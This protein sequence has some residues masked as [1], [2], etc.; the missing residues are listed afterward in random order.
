MN[1]KNWWK[2]AVIYQIYPSSFADGN[3]DGI[4]DFKGIASKMD[5]IK[6]LGVDAVWTSPICKSPMKDFGYDVSDYCDTNER[7]GTR[8]TSYNVCYTKLL[9]WRR[10]SRRR[11]FGGSDLSR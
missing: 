7:F 2:G 11:C 3:N 4:G 6:S 5:Y 1:N 9:R 8:I 10:R